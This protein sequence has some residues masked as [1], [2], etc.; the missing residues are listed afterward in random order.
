MFHHRKQDEVFGLALGLTTLAWIGKLELAKG[1]RM[2][3]AIAL[4]DDVAD[5]LA[6][7]WGN[8]ERQV[9]EIVVVQAY[10]DQVIS[11]GKVRQ[12]LGMATRLEVDAFLKQKGVF[13]IAPI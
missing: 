6:A 9:L 1:K 4:P 8:L 3:I 12:L 10:R 7:R 5:D 2:E 13:L 11:A